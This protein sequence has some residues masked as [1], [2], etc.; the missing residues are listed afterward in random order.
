M[1]VETCYFCSRPSYPGKGIQFVR[2]DGKAFRFCRSKCHK[3][4]KMKRNPR[5]LG[6]TKAYRKAAGKEMTVDSTLQ[7]AQRRNVP[8]RYD[9]TLWEKT[10]QAMTRIQEIRQKRERAHYK[11]RMVGKRARE[12]AADKKL[13]ET[14]SHLLPRMR[15]SERRRLLE[16]GVDPE[17]INQMEETLPTETAKVHGKEKLRQRLRVDGGVEFV[18]EAGNGMDMDS[19]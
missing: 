6:W 14:H 8:V 15:G 4:F 18:P 1:R 10:M 16:Q 13:V 7:F 2:N 19:D 9:R 17:Q 12:L 3:N 5:K 11:R